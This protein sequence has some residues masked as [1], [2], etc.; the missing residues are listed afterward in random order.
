MTHLNT[1]KDFFLI[2][3][4]HPYPGLFSFREE[5]KEYFFGRE[6]EIKALTSL[7]EQ[8][9]LTI[10]F[11]KSGVG[12]TSLLRAGLIPW[13][14][15]NYY[16]PIILRI[17]FSNLE[18]TPLMQVKETIVSELNRVCPPATPFEGLTLWEY[19]SKIKKF[20]KIFNGIA[21]PILIFD[22]FEEIFTTERKNSASIDL[23]FTEISDLIE[24]R[25][26]DPVLKRLKRENETVSH[27]DPEPDLRV[28][29]SLREDY[30]AQLETFYRYIPSIRFSRFRVTEMKGIDAVEAVW[31]PAKELIKDRN[32]AEEIIKK[33]P[34]VTITDYKP[35]EIVDECWESK[36]IE[37]FLLSLFCYRANEE[38]LNK[39]EPQI[40]MRLIRDM[41]TEDL[42][43]D[44][45]E[46][47]IRDFSPHVRIAL[48]E[49]LVTGQGFRKR[50]EKQDL[51]NYN[52]TDE[53]IEKL[54][55]RR[56][57]RKEIRDG[58][59][60]VELI[61]DV[62]AN[63]LKDSRNKRKEEE[64]I[65]KAKRKK[66]IVTFVALFFLIIAAG[67]ILYYL[68][69][70][71][72]IID[73]IR[74]RKKQERIAETEKKKRMTYEWAAY[75]IDVQK[76]DRDLS[77][78]LAEAA[79]KQDPTNL[80][81]RKALL[82]VFYGGGFYGKVF[83]DKESEFSKTTSEKAIFFAAFSPNGRQLLTVTSKKA[84]IW[85]WNPKQIVKDKKLIL[86]LGG[87]LEFSR[88]AVF[89]P[90]GTYIAFCTNDDKQIALWNLS[91]N[92][93]IMLKLEG[94][95]N[96]LTFSP[97]QKNILAASLDKKIRL[98]DLTGERIRAFTE[99]S[100]QV[101]SVAF[102]PDGKWIAG[103][104][105][106]KIVQLEPLNGNSI[107]KKVKR[108]NN[109]IN[110]ISFSP[111]GA[112]LAIGNAD[113]SV[114][115][116]NYKTSESIQDMGKHDEDVSCV[117]FSPDGQYILSTSKDKTTR[118]MTLNN[119]LVIEFKED[120][121]TINTAAFSPDGNYILIAPA[122]GPAQLRPV[123]PEEII[124]IINKRGDVPQLDTAQELT[125]NIKK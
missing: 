46:E 55:N 54:V 27:L 34:G 28:I 79:Y 69:Q 37:P 22:Q 108:F 64:K 122:H 81:A 103:A 62:L 49:L 57:I 32:I 30:L 121:D 101:I 2:D 44:F 75:S 113:G 102:S 43:H 61:H 1:D 118:L 63:I 84:N 125:Y 40:S 98:F 23:F 17:D 117:T 35:F 85:N 116:W 53:D 5:D 42:M 120:K 109:V 8:N 114:R 106:D 78:R 112:K 9:F 41:D 51:I 13:I 72:K 70:K 48:E 67:L 83:E 92:E 111:D 33:I 124:R 47:N 80:V 18:K 10:V 31:K 21:K 6:R 65:E 86:E 71:A 89:S 73:Q 4:Q 14:R 52:V 77:F 88:N 36:K 96:S 123:A 59:E 105:W 82:S 25:L 76:K 110:S 3:N 97:N 91:K 66:R 39:G 60:C 20:N 29:I 107:E 95:V 19:F 12:K 94:G 74:E 11:G 56:I 24:N 15:S 119:F 100:G 38:R 90:D 99:H 104:G 68:D 50:P 115:L 45:Y 93:W 16:V 7:I 87:D 58:K 26:P